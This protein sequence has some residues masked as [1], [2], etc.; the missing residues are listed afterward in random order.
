MSPYQP[1]SQSLAKLL[2]GEEPT[3]SMSMK[4]RQFLVLGS[5]SG[6]GLAILAKVLR[7]QTVQSNPVNFTATPNLALEPTTATSADGLRQP[8]EGQPLLRFVSVADTGTG[9]TGQ[10]AVAAAMARYHQLNPY[11]LVVLAGD[12]IY[13]NGEVRFVG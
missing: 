10:Y 1:C 11:D 2:L 4:R 9:A 5:L 13:N 7:S 3:T 12:N 6:L 8:V